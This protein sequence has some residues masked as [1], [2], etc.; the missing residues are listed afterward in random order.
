MMYLS[1]I[2]LVRA[3]FQNGLL[4][5]TEEFQGDLS[6]IRQRVDTGVGM[7]KT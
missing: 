2:I 6:D 4:N 1:V 7:C 5:L 3:C